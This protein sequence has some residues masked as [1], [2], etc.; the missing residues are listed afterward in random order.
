MG[1][2]DTSERKALPVFYNVVHAV[3]KQCPN[4]RDDVMLIQ[5]LFK[6]FYDKAEVK[7]G[8][9]KPPGEMKVTG[10]CGPTTMSWIIH[11]QRDVYK[12]APGQISLDNRIDRV[13]NKSLV[14]SLTGTIYTLA[15]LNAGVANHNPEA[16]VLIPLLVPL[17][18]P[19][20]VPP[21]SIDIVREYEPMVVPATGGV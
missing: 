5:Y 12:E 21:P 4:V 9:K 10:L 15:W 3:G 7:K 20:N 18:N 2:L 17:T 19:M 6:A 1:F 8:W 13:R 16:F 14:G 11:F